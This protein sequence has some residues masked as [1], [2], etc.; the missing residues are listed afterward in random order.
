MR[1]GPITG[2]VAVLCGT[3]TPCT[4]GKAIIQRDVIKLMRITKIRKNAF[5]SVLTDGF[6]ETFE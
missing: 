1:P 2:A 6:F 3:M 4:V 5:K